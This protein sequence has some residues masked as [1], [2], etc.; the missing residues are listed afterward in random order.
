MKHCLSIFYISNITTFLSFY[1]CTSVNYGKISQMTCQFIVQ[2]LF[3][4]LTLFILMDSP[5][6][7]DRISIDL[8]IMY[9]KVSQVKISKFDFFLRP[10]DKSVY[11]KSI[12]F[13]SH[14]KHM[15]WVLKRTVSMRGFF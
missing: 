14:L 10:A 2:L 4:S 15:L 12:F 6:Y 5:K 8:P 3:P 1:F 7:I 13:I 9:F 11:W